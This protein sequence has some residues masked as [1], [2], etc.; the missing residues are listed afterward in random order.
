[1]KYL[2][3]FLIALLCIAGWMALPVSAGPADITVTSYQVDPTVLMKKDTG[4][5]TVAVKNTGAESVA[6]RSARLFNNGVVA[7]TDPYASVGE[8][9]AGNSK[10]FT[11]TIRADA[12]EGTYYP[13]FVLDFRDGGSLRYPIPIQIEDTPLQ[14]AVVQKPDAFAVDRQADITLRVGNPRP[15]AASG[16]QVIPTGE[17]FSVTP[18]SAFIGALNPDAAATVSF[19]LTPNAE[20]NVTFQVIWRNGI[21]TH[22]ADLAIPILFGEDKRQANLVISNVEVEPE[23]GMYRVTGDITN[24]GLKAAR[25]VV[26]TS[27]SPADP[28]DPFRVYVVGTLDPDDFSSFEVTFRAEPGT[29]EVPLIT[30]YRDADGNLYTTTTSVGIGSAMV[31]PAQGGTIPI[32]GVIIAIVVA[33]GIIGVIIYSWR[34]T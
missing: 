33:A 7:L 14:V 12:P 21:N 30:E 34:R 17:G 4:T 25:S 23:T 15:N 22:T 27:G 18:T 2:H 9:G 13:M 8:I 31:L 5:L 26:V 24:A 32:A 28:T 10:D 6:I 16:V 11:F 1:M 20:T 19:N 3:L 29:T